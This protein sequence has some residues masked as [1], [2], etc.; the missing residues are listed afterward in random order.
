MQWTLTF[1]SFQ[2]HWTLI[3]LVTLTIIAWDIEL[4]TNLIYFHLKIRVISCFVQIRI[5]KI[6][7][8]RQILIIELLTSAKLLRK[9]ICY[10]SVRRNN[11]WNWSFH[12]V[13]IISTVIFSIPLIVVVDNS[14]FR[15]NGSWCSW[16]ESLMVWGKNQVLVRQ[17]IQSLFWDSLIFKDVRVL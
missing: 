8:S 12:L 2:E 13:Y 15:S 6:G 10:H 17:M 11:I 1:T 16:C 4:L 7:L 3:C 5:W 14:F 9:T